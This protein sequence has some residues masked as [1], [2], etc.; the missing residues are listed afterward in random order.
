MFSINPFVGATKKIISDFAC[1]PAD[2]YGALI[3][4][5]GNVA[6]CGHEQNDF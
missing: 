1:G 2:S 4:Q 3:Q 5:R 6:Y